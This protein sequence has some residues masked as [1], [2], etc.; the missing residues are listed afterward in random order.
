[1]SHPPGYESETERAFR[2]ALDRTAAELPHVPDLVGGMHLRAGAIRRRRRT[3]AGAAL[4]VTALVA[5][6]TTVLTRGAGPGGGTE[7]AGPPPTAS[8]PVPGSGSSTTHRPPV[9]QA[10]QPPAPSATGTLL[11]PASSPA[12]TPTGSRPA[13][14]PPPASGWGP[15][16]FDDEFRT[17]TLD[18]RWGPYQGQSGSSETVFEPDQLT[19]ESGVLRLK[20][21]PQP[22]VGPVPAAGINLPSVT[23]R[24]GRVEVRWRSTAAYGVVGQLVFLGEGPSGIGNLATLAAANGSMTVEDLVHKSEK[25]VPVSSATG[26][27][28][29]AM[30]ATPQRVR[31]LLDGVPVADEPGAAPTVPVRLGLQALIPAENCGRVP[32]PAGCPAAATYPQYVDLDY[33]RIWPYQG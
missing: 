25:R 17:A 28:T 29:L 30:E 9:T 5:G 3:V 12:G 21:G 1:M 10:S 18:A 32:L 4:T 20:V 26:W 7:A 14:H 8:G 19:L 2:A 13:G 16:V 6:L 22:R 23:Q 33:V 31:W 11:P 15:A 27:H 24:Y